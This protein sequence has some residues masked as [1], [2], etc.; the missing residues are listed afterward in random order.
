M[1]IVTVQPPTWILEAINLTEMQ[2]Q[3]I[4]SWETN[5]RMN[6]QSKVYKTIRTH[7]LRQSEL[8]IY[9]SMSKMYDLF[10]Y[11]LWN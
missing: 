10:L 6:L 9:R 2:A 5:T 3:T 8:Q 4:E 11:M 1:G 7:K